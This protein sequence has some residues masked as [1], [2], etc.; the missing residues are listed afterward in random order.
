MV[1][2][3]TGNISIVAGTGTYGNGADGG[4]A[5]ATQLN[6][7]GGVAV[8]KSGNLYFADSGNNSIRMVTATTGIITTVAGPGVSSNLGDG[9]PAT[10]AYLNQPKGIA[11]DGA[12]NLYIADTNNNR[13]RMIAATTGIITTVAGG[14]T[15]GEIGDG[16]LA[17]AAYISWPQAVTFDHSQNLYITDSG[18]ARIR[19]VDTSNG[20][21]TT[22][23]GNGIQ[24]NSGDGGLATAAEVDLSSESGIAVDGTGNVYFSNWPD[25]IRKVDAI[26]G[27][28][29]TIAG[30]GYFAYGGDGGAATMAEL[31]GPAGLALDLAGN[32][33]I[34]DSF[35]Y[36][37]RKVT[38]P[39]TAAVLLSPTPGLSTILGASNVT[40]QWSAVATATEYQLNLSA[41]APGDS[42]LY[43]YKGAATSAIVPTL[44]ANGVTVYARLYS[45]SNGTWQH[46]DYLY[47]ESGTAALAVLT[48]PAPGVGT[49]LGTTN[50]VFQWSAGTGVTEYQLNLSAIA[51]GDSDLFTYKGTALTATAATLPKNGVPVYATLYSYVNGAWQSNSYLY[52]ESGTSPGILKS[53]TPGVGT[54]LGTTNVAFQWTTGA[55]VAVYQLNLSAVAAGQSELFSYKGTATTATAPSIPANGAT[56]Y[57]TLYSN[58]NGV[59][60]SNAYEYTE[61]GSP[62]PAILT[63]PT[64]GTTT[65][66]G[67]TSVPFQWSTGGG[68]SLYQ[69]NLSAV[70]A[71][72]SDLF[73]YK[74]T[75]TTATVPSIPTN[76]VT[77]FATLYSLI[78]GAW[79]KNSYVYTESGS[80]TPGALTSPTPG[81][82]TILGTSNVLFQWSAGTSATLY[83]LNLSAI[84]PGEGD[85]YSY[86]GAATSTSAPS[87]P[88]NGVKVYARLYS[89]I[90]GAWLHNDYVYTE[91]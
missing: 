26:I 49:V 29:T 17:T 88:A 3:T 43:T 39:P 13:V 28:I 25:T 12:A 9:G 15:A 38:L 74:G 44:P 69:L 5:T 53:P 6:S 2:A 48:S 73:L 77:V 81:I 20:I 1:G 90:D 33:Y 83:Q 59:W 8:D 23:A 42:D 66:L 71:G 61:S 70:A 37:V 36:V 68:V 19:K 10:S 14:G 27:G 60:Q 91:Q 30:D 78:K 55:G 54:I 76:G 52:T 62:T 34:A 86:K 79:Q 57:A 58:I 45:F 18:N 40:F 56:V 47:T 32:L 75:A 67:T 4:L 89:Y 50:V 80:P 63:S 21:I 11:F 7:P 46:N 64:P 16:G 41:I 31:Y 51:P 72:G 24:G 84:A 35:N 22:I 85:L 65:I 82:G 87:L